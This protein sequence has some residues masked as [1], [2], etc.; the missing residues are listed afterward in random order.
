MLIVRLYNAQ[1][2]LFQ[3][4]KNL[5]TER[6]EDGSLRVPEETCHWFN[7]IVAFVFNELRDS[8]VIKR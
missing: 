6:S 4:L 8:T 3:R 5:L 1:N 2:L 7:L